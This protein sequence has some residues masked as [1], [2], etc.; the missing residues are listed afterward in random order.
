MKIP[1]EQRNSD[2]YFRDDNNRKI[3]LACSMHLHYHLE[4]FLLLDGKSH[5]SIDSEVYDLLPGDFLIVFPNQIH[6]YE[7]IE[8]ERYLLFIVNP[9]L[10]PE[11][12]TVFSRQVPKS[13]VI[14][15]ADQDR[16]LLPL[17]HLLAEQALSPPPH[18]RD[19][20]LKGTLLALF[21]RLL[22]L[23]ELAE[24]TSQD[25]R[26]VRAIVDYCA[27]HY[28]V[29]SLSLEML[30]RD[31][32]L[33][34]FYISHLFSEKMNIRFNDYI[35]SLRVGGACRLLQ[36]TD[37]SMTAISE[38]SGFNTCRTFNRSFVKLLGVS[39][40][41]YRHAMLSKTNKKDP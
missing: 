35:N 15:H 27:K 22:S 40:S 23:L 24:P 32:H 25:S 1:Y 14:R 31:L 7:E 16:Q 37:L 4:F 18:Y 21:S 13:A 6:R 28:T 29:P 34:R 36:Q 26:A 12:S 41:A 30:E 20:A 33:S 3:A 8:R 2:L 17:L 19:L 5:V 9:D 38:K 11:F 10:M 39:P